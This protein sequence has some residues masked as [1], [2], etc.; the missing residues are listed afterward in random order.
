M[1]GPAEEPESQVQ[2]ANRGR[3]RFSVHLQK[4]VAVLVTE[5]HAYR[6]R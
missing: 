4:H 5:A 3:V 2:V 6:A 1:A